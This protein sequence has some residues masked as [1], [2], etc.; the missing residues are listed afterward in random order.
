M[1]NLVCTIVFIA[2][3]ALKVFAFG[4]SGYFYSGWNRFDFFVVSTSIFDWALSN[5]SGGSSF[6]RVGPQLARIFRILRITRLLKIVRSFR[7][8][9]RLIEVSIMAL[10]AVFNGM[11]LLILSYFIFS[12]L[13]VFLF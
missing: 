7:T 11:T 2:E 4:A 12:I 1:I 5:N 13:A 9:Q 10:P 3:C 8:L 6:L